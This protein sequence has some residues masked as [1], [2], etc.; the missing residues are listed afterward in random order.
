MADL[1]RLLWEFLLDCL[2]SPEQLRAE[3]V[4]LRHQLNVLRRKASKRPK[5][6]KSDRAIFVWVYRMFPGAA[7]AITII[8]PETVIGWHWAGFRAWWR[9][10]VP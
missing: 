8:R 3:N 9:W 10:E 1:A 7:G 4:T 6:S 2:R 5:L